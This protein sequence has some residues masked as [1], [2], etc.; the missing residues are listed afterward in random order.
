MLVDGELVATAPRSHA[1]D[2]NLDNT[3]PLRWGA[4]A[5]EHLQ[6]GLA[7]CRYYGRALTA[8]E[9]LALANPD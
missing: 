6:G 1:A 2:F 7:D 5:Y 8:A 4:G 3:Q 9:I